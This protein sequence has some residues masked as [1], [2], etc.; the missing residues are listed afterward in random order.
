MTKLRT[1]YKAQWLIPI[2]ILRLQRWDKAK[3]NVFPDVWRERLPRH[4]GHHW[5][6]HFGA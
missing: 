1:W 2:R 4:A 3:S 5:Y 6:V